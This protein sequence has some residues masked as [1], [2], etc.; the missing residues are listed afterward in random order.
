MSAIFYHDEEQKHIAEET[1][2]AEQEKHLRPITTSILPFS[3]FYIAEDYHQKYLLQRHPVLMNALDIDPGDDLI[4]NHVAARINGYV[5]GY[6]T[7]PQFDKE[8]H[9]WGINEKMA[10]YIRKAITSS[11]RDLC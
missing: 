9:Q 2:R 10:D 6:G 8:W 4:D 5:G 11:P 7:V 1:M 3:A